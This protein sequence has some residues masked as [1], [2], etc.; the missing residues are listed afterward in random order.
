[1]QQ[2]TH[3]GHRVSIVFIVDEADERVLEVQVQKLLVEVVLRSRLHAGF[4][5][6]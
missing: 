5:S 2:S 6:V 4:L 1:V 3:C